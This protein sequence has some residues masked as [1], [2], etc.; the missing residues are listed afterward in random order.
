MGSTVH[1]NSILIQAVHL[2]SHKYTQLGSTL[3]IRHNVTQ[4]SL[5]LKKSVEPRMWKNSLGNTQ[6][7]HF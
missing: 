2:S 4:L 5:F 6:R 1:Q 3:D 7:T